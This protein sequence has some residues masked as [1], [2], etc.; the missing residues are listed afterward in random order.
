MKKVHKLY[1]AIM[2]SMV[3]LAIFP[4]LALADCPPGSDVYY[5][6]EVTSSQAPRGSRPNPATDKTEAKNI[7]LGCSGGAYLWA[8]NADKDDY[9][10]DDVVIPEEKEQTGVPLAQSVLTALL[11]CIAGGLLVWGLYQRRRLG[12]I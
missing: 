8:F 4:L 1:W 9:D 2:L 12:R 7:A 5:G 6:G 10:Y 3:I 11:G